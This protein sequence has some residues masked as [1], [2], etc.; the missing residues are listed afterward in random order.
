MARTWGFGEQER[1]T[2]AGFADERTEAIEMI[3]DDD[4]QRLQ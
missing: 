1:T 2:V 4:G 3:C